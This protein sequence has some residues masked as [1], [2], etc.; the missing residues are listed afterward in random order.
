MKV[1]VA[2][3]TGFLGTHLCRGALER[4]FEVTSLST[5]DPSAHRELEGVEYETVDLT[6][7]SPNMKFKPD[8][9]FNAAGYVHHPVDETQE[10][11]LLKQHVSI[12]RNLLRIPPA[13]GAR[14]IHLGSGDE[15]D[16]ASSAVSE[17]ASAQGYGPYG[18]VK[19]ASTK[20]AL[21]EAPQA[22]FAISILRLFLI[23]G[24]L[25]AENRLVP[26]LIRG[27]SAGQRVAL[28]SGSQI[29][30]FLYIDDFVNA[31]FACALAPSTTGRVLNVSSDL[32]TTVSDLADLIHELIG[33]GEI[34]VGDL[35]DSRIQVKVLVGNSQLLRLL[36]DWKPKVGVREGLLRTIDSFR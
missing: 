1:I 17:R 13:Q 6:S 34:G 3:G 8:L 28:S 26:Q 23:F 35:P 19:A 24:P 4:G 27:L 15:Y 10:A 32:P 2:G 29:R 9:I 5:S 7:A 12:V 33:I 11:K 22:G 25:Q 21:S 16:E 18:R 14:F 20:V 31:A 36:T 30:D